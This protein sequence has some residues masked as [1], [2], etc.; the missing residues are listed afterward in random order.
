MT[1]I[2]PVRLRRTLYHRLFGGPTLQP[3]CLVLWVSMLVGT[4]ARA[5]R[6]EHGS[7]LSGAVFFAGVWALGATGWAEADEHGIR[8][9]GYWPTAVGWG[10]VREVRSETHG[11][12]LQG[13]RTLLV[14]QTVTRR[15]PIGPAAGRGAN[16]R[17]FGAAL[18]QL[19]ATRAGRD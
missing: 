8:W 13:V 12:G 1:T 17:G 7:A 4:A 3:L 15:R 16:Q 2:V 18:Q 6:G 11:I 5:A 14:V 9:R 10:E 19:A